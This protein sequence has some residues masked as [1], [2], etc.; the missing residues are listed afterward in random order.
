MDLQSALGDKFA[1]EPPFKDGLADE[2]IRI[3]HIPL[4]FNH[5]PAVR[6]KVFGNGLRDSVVAQVQVAAAPF[7]HRRSRRERDFEHCPALETANLLTFDNGLE[8]LGDG[9]QHFLQPKMS[10]AL[11]AQGGVRRWR[12]RLSMPALRA[13]YRDPVRSC[14][15][16]GKRCAIRPRRARARFGPDEQRADP[17]RWSKGRIRSHPLS[18]ARPPSAFR[19]PASRGAASAQPC[20]D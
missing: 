13:G 5:K 20:W 10:M 14:G 4:F 7:A 18:K 3:E 6:A 11:L 1:D 2:S 19:P 15:R 16:H 17:E 9:M 8:W 12:L